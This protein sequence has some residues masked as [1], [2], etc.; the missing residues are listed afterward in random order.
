MQASHPDP[1]A[2]DW[3]K[4]QCVAWGGV[5]EWMASHA[6]DPYTPGLLMHPVYGK[7]TLDQTPKNISNSSC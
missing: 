4:H 1:T 5:E 7:K 2:L 6:F 3:G